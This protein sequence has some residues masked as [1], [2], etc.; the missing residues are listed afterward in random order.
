MNIEFNPGSRL[1]KIDILF[2][3]ISVIS[4]IYL[5]AYSVVL[6]FCIFFVVGHF[7]WFCN[8]TRMSRKPELIW[9]C[10][11]TA[12]SITTVKFGLPGWFYTFVISLLVTAIL[13]VL[14][15][16]KPSYHGIYWK[17]LNPE[18]PSWFSRNVQNKHQ[19]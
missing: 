7:F 8:I 11:F 18:L 16:H 3:F 1:S 19:C 5:Y 12:F 13:T 4:A 9:A 14:E 10:V 15:I 2:I 6:S 17:K